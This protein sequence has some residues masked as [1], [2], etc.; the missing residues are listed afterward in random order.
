MNAAATTTGAAQ[1][2]DAEGVLM[3]PGFELDMTKAE[4]PSGRADTGVEV[5]LT[6]LH[7]LGWLRDSV[8]G[9]PV[10]YVNA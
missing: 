5:D 2:I 1:D 8:L 10:N 9:L 7:I 3:Q 6:Y 4:Q